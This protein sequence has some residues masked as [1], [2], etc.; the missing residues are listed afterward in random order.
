MSVMQTTAKPA[1]GRP[2]HKLKDQSADQPSPAVPPLPFTAVCPRIASACATLAGV[3]GPVV[4]I[5]P[6]LSKEA[7][8]E[9]ALVLR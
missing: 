2:D 4:V 5:A 7:C 8:R 3:I 6:D 9:K 1:P